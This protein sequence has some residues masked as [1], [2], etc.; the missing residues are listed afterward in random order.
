MLSTLH[1]DC[2]R[3]HPVQYYRSFRKDNSKIVHS[4]K[5]E[6]SKAPIGAPPGGGFA[7]LKA[8]S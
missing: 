6:K 3:F 5:P 8:S 1:I 2:K 4:L 7:L